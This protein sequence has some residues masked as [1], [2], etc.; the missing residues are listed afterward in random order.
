MRF[1]KLKEAIEIFI[2]YIDEDDH[3]GGADHDVIFFVPDDHPGMKNLTE[4]DRKRLDELGFHLDEDDG[5]K[6]YV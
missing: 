3:I 4:K 6:I 2:K 5:W 1:S